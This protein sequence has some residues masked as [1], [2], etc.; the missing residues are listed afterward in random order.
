MSGRRRWFAGTWH[1]RFFG[2]PG[3]WTVPVALFAL[4]LPVAIAG[5]FGMPG[6]LAGHDGGDGFGHHGGFSF[7]GEVWR[8]KKLPVTKGV[9]AHLLQ[10]KANKHPKGYKA[11]GTYRARAAQWPKAGTAVV[12]L[13]SP[14]TS[15]PVKAGS[16]PV[17]VAPADA[18][19]GVDSVRVQAASH[20]QTLRTGANGMLLGITP[21]GTRSATG[22]VKVVIDYSAIARA[23]GGGYGSRLRL[24]QLPGCALTTPQKPQCQKSTPL[25]F[26]NRAGA[27]QL[28]ATVTMNSAPG[29]GAGTGSDTPGADPSS[30]ASASTG[31][32]QPADSASGSSTPAPTA[33]PSQSG[34]GTAS[35]KPSDSAN[36]PAAMSARTAPLT[37]AAAADTTALAVTSGASGSQG[38]Y[39]ATQLSAAG[40]WQASATGSFTYSYPISVP[41]AIGGNA[42]SV[43]LS[44]DSQSVDGETTARNAQSSWVGDG[45][46]YQVGYV[47]RGYRSCGSLLDSDDKKILKGSGDECWGGDNATLSFGSHSGVLVPDGTD[48]GVPGEIKQWRL[49][50][51]DG[52]VVQELSGAAN[53]LHDGLYYR[54][55]TTDGTAAYFGADH[56]PSGPGTGATMDS[57][58]AD[59]STHSA[60]GVPVL[61]PRSADPCHTDADGKKSQCDKPEGWRWNLDF[62]VSPTGFVQRYDYTAETNYYDLGGGQAGESDD[63]DDTG[64]LTSYTR[65]GALTL[66]SYGYRLA[67]EQAGRAPAAE[68]DFGLAQRCQTTSTFTDCSSGNL[69]DSTATHWPDVPWDLHCDSTDKTKM[70]DGATKVPEDV[71]VTSGPSFWTTTRLDSITTKVHVKAT[72]QLTAVDSYSLG[73][74]YSDAGGTVDPVTGTT[75]DPKDAGMLQAVMWLQSVQHTGKDTYGNGNSDIRL[76]QV[77]FTGTEI[78]NRVDDDSP[79][80]PPLYRPRISSIQTETGESIAVE[81]NP[82]PC[83]GK[84]LDIKQ[85]DSNTN[86]CYPVYWTVPGASKPIADWFNKVTVNS[87]AV[88]DLTIAGQYKPDAQNNPAG[89]ETQISRYS[90][91]G[92]AWHRDDSAQA[93]DRYRTWDQFRGFRSV[94]VNTGQAPEPVTR[95][96]TT[97]LQGMDGDYKADGTRRSVTVDAKVGGNTVLSVTDADQLAGTTLEDETYTKEGGTVDAASVNGP[98]TFTTTASANQ[99][100]WTD[101]TQ[102]DNPGDTRPALS[103]LPDLSAHRIKASSSREYQ[104]LADGTWRHTSTD[105]TYDSQGRVST[106]NGHGDGTDPKQ[107]KCATTTYADPPASNT[108]MLSYADRVTSVVGD[109]STSVSASSLLTDKK[110]YY[111]GDGTPSGLG[112]FGQVTASG[113]ATG[114]QT[115]T[116]FTNATENWQTTSAMTYDGGGRVTD[117]YDATGQKTHTDFD[118]DWSSSGGNTNATAETSVNSQNWQI[119]STFDALRGLTLESVDANGRKTD[120]TYDA[121]GR[122]TAVWEPG[123]DKASGQSADETFDYAIN[124]GAV[125]A[126]G[127][128]IT[129]P[130]APSSVTTRTLRD[131]G[132]YATSI[133]LY[134][135]MLQP[136]QTQSTAMGD[137]N[138]GRIISDT[139]YDSHGWQVA[140]YAA[141]S[142]PGNFPTT[143]LYAA[144]ENQIPSETTTTYDG[145]GRPLRQTLWHQ[146]VEQWHTSASYPGADETDTT[147]PAG[148]RA[149]A[150]FTDAVGQT[151]RTVVKNTGSTVSLTGG[152]VIPS[153]TSLTSD[154]VRLTMQADGN[155]VLSA[156]ATGKTI[157]SSGTSGNPGAWAKFG[158]DGNLVLFST[159]A[160]QLWTTGLTATTGATFQIRNDS[161][162]AVVS[163]GGSTL[164]KQGTA[165]AVPA[166]DATTRY[167][168]T[169]AGQIDSIKDSAGNSWSYTYNALGQKTSQ[170]DPNAGKTTYDKYDVAGNLLQ[171]TDPRGQVLSFTYDW[172]NR[173]TAE[174]AG[175]WSATPP[176]DK[177][178]AS[179]VYDT[180]EKGYQTSATRYVGGASGTAYTQAVTGYNTAYQPLGTT[181]TVPSADGFAAAGQSTAPTSGTVTYTSTSRYTP[182]TGLLSTT[183]YQADG[184]LPAEDI[185]YGYTQQGNLDGI[186]G[187]INSANT[188]A[189]LDTAVHDAF[190]RVLQADYGRTGKELA[191]FA[192]YDDTTGRVTQASSM[193]QTSTTALDVI[194]LRY[195]QAG[196]LT[197]VDDLQDNTTHDT[198]CFTYDSFQRLTTAWTDTAG[199]TGPG[200][201]TPGAVG[202]C[203]TARVQT[204]TTTPIRTTTVGGPAPYWQTYTYDQLGD[205]TGMV[206][207]DTTGNA[208]ND[209]T[210]SVGYAGS[211]GTAAAALPDQTGT[212]TTA[213][214]ATG[215][216]TTTATYADPSY[217]NLNAGDTTSRKV[218]S[219]GPLSTAFT[220]SGGGK[221]CIEDAG[222]STTAGA[223]VQIDTCGTATGQKWTIGT[224]GTVKVLGMCL[225]TAG[226]ATA[227][228]TLVVIDTCKTD[229]TQK[230]KVTTTGTLVSNANSALCL[231]DPGASATN[232]TQLTIATCGG[233]GQTWTNAATGAVAA[234]Q[235]QTFTYDAEGRTSTVATTSGTHTSTS[236]YLYD[237]QGDLLEQTAAVDGTDK[238]RILYLFGGAEQITLNVSAKTWTGLRNID[239]PDGT[240]ITRSSS[241]SVTYQIANGQGTSVT[242]VDAASLAV[243]RRSYDPWGN[244]RG[245]KPTSWVAPDENHGFL[246]QPADPTTG[247]N[248]LGARDYDPVL[249]RFLTP[250]PVFETGDPNQMGGYTYAGDNPASGSDPS[251]LMLAMDGGGGGGCDA[252][253][254]AANDKAYADTS[255]SSGQKKHHSGGCHGFFGCAGHY[256]KKAL[257][258]VETVVTVVVVVVAVAVVVSAC[259]GTVV[260]AP[261][262]V[263]GAA[264]GAGM[265]AGM[266][267]ADCAAMGCAGGG[268]AAE[269]GESPPAGGGSDAAPKAAAEPAPH[270]AAGAS[271]GSGDAAAASSAGKEAASDAEGANAAKPK[272]SDAQQE[273]TAARKTAAASDDPGTGNSGTDEV[274]QCSFSPDTPVLMAGGRTKAIGRIRAGDKVESANAADGSHAG[275]RE[276]VAT[277]VNHD[278]DLVDVT[279]SLGHGRTATLH[280]TSKHPFWD[281]TTRTWVPAGRLLAGHTLTTEN[282]RHVLIARIR[283]TPGAAWRYNLTVRELHTYYV[284]AGGVPVLVHN[285][286]GTEGH[287]KLCFCDSGGPPRGV[288]AAPGDSV[289]LGVASVGVPLAQREGAMTFNGDLYAYKHENYEGA[290]PQWADEVNAA[291]GNPDVHIIVDLGG[292]AEDESDPVAVFQNAVSKGRAVNHPEKTRGTEWEMWRIFY[293]VFIGESRPW[294]GI[295]WFMRGEDVTEQMKE[296]TP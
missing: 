151:T 132:T 246:G 192:Q 133:A 202:G 81:Y 225:D 233:S 102:E 70:P 232:A 285:H 27:E 249:G 43:G 91:T 293:H 99:T 174:Y 280:T 153:G 54:V 180:L 136:R 121:L 279:L 83:A 234:G 60:W 28:T 26:T 171:T 6:F 122:R 8:P 38:D 34:R 21:S 200:A 288:E 9:G 250:D 131:D 194:N 284:V 236:K 156:L 58:P 252:K 72:D 36:G 272:K 108:M 85:A 32:P 113:R 181:L 41:A 167:A 16:L 152:S 295:R 134:D 44:Y 46:S 259:A 294:S 164:W 12:D 161:T 137:S 187:F 212:A 283:A 201:A 130:G 162:A 124:P 270:D 23:Y 63:P 273:A 198:Q 146:A 231:T 289:V 205:R 78:D 47:E 159:A 123:R 240:T 29:D 2:G 66:I 40:S 61:H 211:D 190:G 271:G 188:P 216:A 277:L 165:N 253:C 243:T 172:D 100:P 93:D 189:Y 275:A 112:A 65:G 222:N 142:E 213:N 226:N 276:V 268:F 59:P 37:A 255:T 235:S 74:V 155:L 84:S 90:Y 186:G 278:K 182:T 274:T 170:T 25:K 24:V 33:S 114:T 266:F 111:A 229:A 50:G 129:Q 57:S 267:G 158:T 140:S 11:L 195:D 18:G 168:Y 245:T 69:K 49:Q 118:P 144:N 56:A 196:E 217:G 3:W 82:H 206:N 126:P 89:S 215:T 67:D 193:L 154:S 135:G 101:W 64:T 177:L 92:P 208:L 86:A 98:F 218:T 103:T 263:L 117:A 248:L 179:H 125:P 210:Q 68:V 220:L 45:W 147:A 139:F 209:T 292:L 48:P 258:V 173:P 227:A 31:S 281:A 79:S 178:L 261:A 62:V 71:C 185:D 52:T 207:H 269:E 247:L 22:R 73:Q 260:A 76:N 10:P 128:T 75:V 256:F 184:N 20:T 282:G 157:W 115:A 242:S 95:Q 228:G 15:K 96:T 55:L 169:A 191:T 106:V 203:T 286:C 143:T 116:G 230:W 287:S 14:G 160:V 97:Y 149:T 104:L 204:G 148:G 251:G 150:T 35:P 13:G 119:T 238:T 166:A 264:E 138:S 30:R 87:V 4:L 7:D 175:A 88:S 39:G 290:F 241:G 296:Y 53:G 145:E 110:I 94:T 223:K 107:E 176:A 19:H 239:G 265:V 254:A 244:P 127:G 262:C 42:P 5:G 221:K 237:A 214:P 77:S 109:C 1:R 291:L 141:Y 80:A 224:D 105:T 257:P 219:T 51:D 163:S 197:A 199:I 120:M 183:H 17:W